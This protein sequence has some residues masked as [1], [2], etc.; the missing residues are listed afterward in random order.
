MYYLGPKRGILM[1]SH[2]RS[3]GFRLVTDVHAHHPGV[4]L[5]T[6]VHAHHTDV[7]LVTIVHAHIILD[8]EELQQTSSI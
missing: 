3:K 2:T 6:I 1:F 8:S 4:T 5:F 7:T